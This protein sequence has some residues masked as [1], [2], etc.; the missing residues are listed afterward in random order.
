MKCSLIYEGMQ[1][2]IIENEKPAADKLIRML[3]RTPL[4]MELSGPLE[5][6]ESAIRWL[7]MHETPDII[8][9]DIQ[10]D[11]GICFEIFEVVQTDAP[12][13]FTTAYDEYAIRAF[14]TNS[15]D[16]LLKPIEQEAL[17]A[18]LDKYQNLYQ[19]TDRS[20]ISRVFEEL[21]RNY[22]SRFFIRVGNQYKSIAVENIESF[23]ISNRVIYIKTFA[24]K[25]YD[26]DYSLEQ[27][28]KMVDPS[29]FFRISR[30]TMINI[31]AVKNIHIY[32]T[33]RLKLDMINHYD[34]DITVS[35]DKV[36]DFKR[37]M[38]R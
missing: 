23:Y 8:F 7:N 28:E 19:K 27:I 18:A 16:Y 5:T 24:G 35:R 32:S 10:L 2:L 12:V 21:T 29:L 4:T 14:K 26:L 30:T 25:N 22:K 20:K 33:S 9:M 6:V 11:D 1:A 36:A 37:W 38:D 34:H 13:V 17:D 31:H 3:K 15:L